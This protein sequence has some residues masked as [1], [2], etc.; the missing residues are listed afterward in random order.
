M[1][2]PRST[3]VAGWQ[4]G[5]GSEVEGFRLVGRE[6]VWTQVQEG[7]GTARPVS[8]R[9]RRTWREVAAA[10]CSVSGAQVGPGQAERRV[11]VSWAWETVGPRFSS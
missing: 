2:I 8:G 7:E 4:E 5:P 1:W 3:R 10:G 6:G 11:R 9:E